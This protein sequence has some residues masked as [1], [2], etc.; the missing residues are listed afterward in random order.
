MRKKR[1]RNRRGAKESVGNE[2][3]DTTKPV[4]E[5]VE[6]SQQG[7]TV[8]ADETIYLYVYTC[9]T[10][11]EEGKLVVDARISADGGIA[12]MD[13]S[14]DAGK[15]CYVCEYNLAGTSAEKVNISSIKVTD[16]A[17]NYT[18][19]SCYENG[20]Y[21][22][23]VSVEQQ[24]SE[25]IHIKKFELKQNGQTLNEKDVLEMSLETEEDIKEEYSVYARFELDNGTIRSPRDFYLNISPLNPENRKN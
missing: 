9:D 24:T 12:Y 1:Y 22:Y 6:F 25:E 8:K 2:Q 3:Y 17:G 20:G 14:F 5:K 21:Q 7:I 11:T 4:I 18:E 23:W 10:G 19:Y 13:T 16:L 15:G